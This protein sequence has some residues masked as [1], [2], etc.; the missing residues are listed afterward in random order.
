METASPF[1]NL[2]PKKYVKRRYSPLFVTVVEDD[3]DSLCQF[4]GLT[5]NQYFA[6]VA[7]QCDPT[8]R[9][10][11]ASAVQ[12]EHQE[13]YFAHVSN[14]TTIYSQSFIFQEY[15]DKDA[16]IPQLSPK[17][18]RFPNAFHY[19]SPLSMK[20]PWYMTMVEN[21]L[22][23]MQFSDF[24]FCDL[25]ACI[26]YVTLSC[27][28]NPT[29]KIEE[30][31]KS[32]NFP[33]WMQEFVNEIPI[34]RIVVYD[35]L[36]VSKPP[37][38]CNA[39][40]GAFSQVIPL[41]F[42]TRRH[43]SPGE[44]DP[45]TLRNL[46]KYDEKLMEHPQ[47]CGFLSDSDLDN[48]KQVIKSIYQVAVSNIEQTLRTHQYEIENSKQL[49]NRVKGWFSKKAPDRLTDFK[50]VP[51]RK[52]I[53]L[54]VAA[55]ELL[56]GR[57]ESARKNYKLFNSS[58]HDG[59]FQE[60]RVFSLYMAAMASVMLP[61]GTRM[62]REVMDDVM[63]NIQAARSIR[64]LIMAPAIAI[65]FFDYL[66]RPEISLYMCRMAITKINILWTGNQTIK[67]LFLGMFFERLA[68]LMKDQRH[69]MLQT[70]RAANFYKQ[71]NQVPHALR[72]YI[73]LART[74]PRESWVL[75]YQ[76]VW[77]EKAAALCQLQQWQRALNDCKNL[78]A[79]PDLDLRLH[80]R[81]ISQFWTP[82]NDSTL[83]KSLL[84]TN[85]NSLLEVK[86]L[87]M[88]DKTHPSYWGLPEEEFEHLIKDFDEYVRHTMSRTTSVS[89]DSWYDEEDKY[90]KA[91]TIRT[92]AVGTQIILTIALY[93]RYKFSVHLDRAILNAKYEGTSINEK[94]FEMETVVRKDI[95]GFTRKTTSVNFKFVP[96]SEGKYI[97]D[98]F[99]KNYWGYVDT[100]V[101][102]GP[103]EF[104]AIKDLP[105]LKMEIY[106]FPEE[107]IESQCYEF[108]INVTNIGN[109]L[110]HD[111][112]ILFD[113]KGTI[114][115]DY[116]IT[117]LESVSFITIHHE[118]NPMES[119]LVDLVLWVKSAANTTY[120]FCAASNGLRCAFDMKKLK[121]IPSS[122][123]E[124]T[125]C[126]KADDTD[127][128]IFHCNFTSLIDGLEIIGAIDHNSR[129]LKL[130]GLDEENRKLNKDESVS[131]A[132][133]SSD[134]TGE[135]AESWRSQ[136]I[137]NQ[138]LAIIYQL[139]D[140]G[141][142]AQTTLPLTTKRNT[143]RFKL[144]VANQI[145]I[146][147]DSKVSCRIS[148][149][150]RPN[151]APLII[152]PHPFVFINH[153]HE[154]LDEK[155]KQVTEDVSSKIKGCRWFGVTRKVLN[156]E[157]NF[158]AELFFDPKIS[159]VYNIPSVKVSNS[160]KFD[161]P[162]LIPLSQNVRIIPK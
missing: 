97:V 154:I 150:D 127:N 134:S 85:I 116:K 6:A 29:K 11:D 38:D 129:Y 99:T 52:V 5:F 71:A 25:P 61:D 62:F 41:C 19:P 44:I 104:N 159:G 81:V 98:S 51:W 48:C 112:L 53:V 123:F 135:T 18:G 12:Q 68:G 83:D 34:V 27:S 102:C 124:S 110:V 156:K 40:R 132:G 147:T 55:L 69:S 157:N 84:H 86:S 9:V 125:F 136:M 153:V 57:Y 146:P 108:S 73:W 100:V 92:V 142:Y 89:F 23:S 16:T 56:L 45:V 130:I 141:L 76:D 22:Q 115:G 66:M 107:A 75:L 122:K 152:E 145:T 7:N 151:D 26:V 93:N 90:R 31:R 138:S 106:D 131:F 60:L 39:P 128:M 77:L 162:S 17:P 161:R 1:N 8:V 113:N 10:I 109:A 4:C 148:L 94:H 64:F 58:I 15:E 140:H 49:S 3:V 2:D 67:S 82:F 119:H 160:F 50:Q 65:E 43:G 80:E 158:S 24:D 20:P 47:F 105:T 21:L 36:L 46:F 54:K 139:P 70:S 79:L 137:N 13:I 91:N 155:K 96:L 133:Y 63:S 88:T 121:I 149:L 72:C 126:K 103:L 143:Y 118:L 117:N 78:L 74:L 87:T 120:H 30:V 101:D 28:N 114:T 144:E 35:G 14:D 33:E 42:R 59:R 32:I 111:F 37:A 95:A